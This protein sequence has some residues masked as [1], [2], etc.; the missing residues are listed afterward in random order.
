MRVATGEKGQEQVQERQVR[1]GLNNRIQAEVLEGLQEGER[2]V[3][4]DAAG[5][6]ASARLRGPRML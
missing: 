4:G 2:V 5:D 6:K 3:V 1:I